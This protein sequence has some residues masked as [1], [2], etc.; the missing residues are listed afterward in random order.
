M[1]N[2]NYDMEELLQRNS[3]RN[4]KKKVKNKE[5][6][7]S[8]PTTFKKNTKKRKSTGQVFN[9]NS[10]QERELKELQKELQKRSIGVVSLSITLKFLI[11][12]AYNK[13][14]DFYKG[15]TS[16]AKDML[17]KDN[18]TE[19]TAMSIF[20]TNETKQRLNGIKE[21]IQEVSFGNVYLYRVV[22]CLIQDAYKNKD[23]LFDEE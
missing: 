5:S 20:M 19:S 18:A 10:T 8:S 6:T 21:Q 1:A 23:T 13:D 9:F 17:P 12:R 2:I 11:N 15:L 4:D 7:G 22:D 3:V 14:K 16:V